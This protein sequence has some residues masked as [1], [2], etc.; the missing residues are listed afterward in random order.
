MNQQRH[1]DRIGSNYDREIFDV[2]QSDRLGKLKS[3]FEK[4]GN[5]KH[6]AIDF[7]CGTGKALPYLAP[8]FKDVLAVDISSELLNQAR[9]RGYPNVEFQQADLTEP[10]KAPPADFAFC[11]NVI[12]LPDLDKNESMF[13]NI[14]KALRKDGIAVLV[15]PSL[16]SFFYSAWRLV[17]W[18]AKEG[19]K[20][21][22]IMSSEFDGF[23]S[24][25]RDLIRGLVQIDGVVTKHYSL[26]ELEVILPQFGFSILR[27]HRLEYDWN[28]EFSEPPKWMKDPF[29]WDWLVELKV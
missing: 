9:E 1:W 23:K 3:V 5:K 7:G 10:F 15:L 16:D 22:D 18:Y 17:D 12:M 26:P 24:P 20:P 29:P 19:A 14:R 8:I 21:E 11:C 4:Y 6:A 27:I 2:F 25:K 28:T 13:R